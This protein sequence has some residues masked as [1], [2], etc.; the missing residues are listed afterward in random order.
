M[1]VLLVS[2]LLSTKHRTRN[3]YLGESLES[4]PYVCGVK[5]VSHAEISP[6]IF[7]AL[8]PVLPSFH[9]HPL[10]RSRYALGPDAYS[11]TFLKYTTDGAPTTRTPASGNSS[12]SGPHPSLY[13]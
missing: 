10:S 5:N 13:S 1:Y 3:S 12:D 4:L 2:Y 9:Q 11:G 7:D 8:L 6:Q